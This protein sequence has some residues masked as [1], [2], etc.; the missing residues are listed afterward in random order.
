VAL[1][2]WRPY[3]E[4]ALVAFGSFQNGVDTRPGLWMLLEGGH[5]G[6][7]LIAL[8]RILARVHCHDDLERE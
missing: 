7:D 1:Q 4:F 3:K 2:L 5:E 8:H 6:I